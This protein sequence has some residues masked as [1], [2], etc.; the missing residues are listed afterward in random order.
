MDDIVKEYISN[1]YFRTKLD[2]FLKEL[3]S[4]NGVQESLM[5]STEASNEKVVMDPERE[6]FTTLRVQKSSED[7]RHQQKL[8][9]IK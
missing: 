6:K 3:E 5:G 4:E 2:M 9:H 1:A 8:I 7:R